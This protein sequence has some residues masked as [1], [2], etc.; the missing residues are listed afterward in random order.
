MQ[1][2]D[3]IRI[4]AEQKIFGMRKLVKFGNSYG[5]NLPR[6]WVNMNCIEIDGNYYLKLEVENNKLIF[7]PIDP[8]DIE[9][10][11]VKKKEEE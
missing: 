7:S 1:V 5:I 11:V 8:S 3:K 10:V 6:T 2:K 9:G 4:L